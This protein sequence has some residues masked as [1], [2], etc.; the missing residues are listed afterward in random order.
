MSIFE[1]NSFELKENNTV[2]NSVLKNI[3]M[4]V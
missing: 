2:L 3:L 1:I 4:E